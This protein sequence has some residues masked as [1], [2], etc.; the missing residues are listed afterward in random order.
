MLKS[1]LFVFHSALIIHHYRFF[2]NP[3]NP[4]YPVNLS[5]GQKT[6]RDKPCPYKNTR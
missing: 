4:V 2:Y 1:A 5:F 6:G 3:V